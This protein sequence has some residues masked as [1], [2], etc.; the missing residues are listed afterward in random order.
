MV[1][2]KETRKPEHKPSDEIEFKLSH[3]AGKQWSSDLPRIVAFQTSF[4][5]PR[6]DKKNPLVQKS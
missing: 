3:H 1:S 5:N 2:K 4:N 6:K